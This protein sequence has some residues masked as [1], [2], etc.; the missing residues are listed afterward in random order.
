[1]KNN[2]MF[3]SKA[4]IEYGECRRYLMSITFLFLFALTCEN[5]FPTTI[6]EKVMTTDEI[7]LP[8]TSRQGLALCSIVKDEW[9]EN[10]NE[11]LDYHAAMGVSKIYLM[12][13]NSSVPLNTI[14][15]DRISSGAVSYHFIPDN[16]LPN[17]QR[18]AYNKC[19]EEFSN[20]HEFM[21][22]LDIDEYVVVVNRSLSIYEVVKSYEDFGGLTL[23]WMLFGS[24]GHVKRPVGGTISNYFKCIPNYHVKT[25]V[26]TAKVLATTLDPHH[27]EY[28]NRS[29]AVDT[30]RRPVLGPFNPVYVDRL[31]NP[32]VL[33]ASVPVPSH[34]YEVMYINHY[35]VKS[36]E[37]FAFKLRRGAPDGNTRKTNYF[38]LV[39]RQATRICPP[40]LMPP[41]GKM[42]GHLRRPDSL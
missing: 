40:L 6:R 33:N 29:F 4:M 7:I 21:G 1:M 3:E 2:V 11:W 32:D 30:S 31:T 19:I 28:K 17:A 24:S 5:I 41:R 35:A 25:I 12:D 20:R 18:F 39:E 15:G 36:A 8:E 14:V 27:F 23:N 13:N 26:N 22:F 16:R 42:I 38:E 10:L 37:D 9:A 34:L